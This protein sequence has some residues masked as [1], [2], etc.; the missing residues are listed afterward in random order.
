MA[1]HTWRYYQI[2]VVILSSRALTAQYR[3]ACYTSNGKNYWYSRQRWHY[4]HICHTQALRVAKK[5]QRLKRHLSV[6][7]FVFMISWSCSYLWLNTNLNLFVGPAVRRFIFQSWT[8]G[9]QHMVRVC[10]WEATQNNNLEP[11][12]C[13]TRKGLLVRDTVWRRLDTLRVSLHFPHLH[14]MELWVTSV[15]RLPRTLAVFV[16]SHRAAVPANRRFSVALLCCVFLNRRIPSLSKSSASLIH[17][18]E[19]KSSSLSQSSL[20]PLVVSL[21]QLYP[22]CLLHKYST[23]EIFQKTEDI[24]EYYYFYY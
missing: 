13:L 9:T 18:R 23:N 5:W 2:Y 16:Q 20:S 7:M 24:H 21:Q 17:R 12:L 4:C 6:S 19:N 3:F 11:D 10:I 15:L 8:R 22:H 1:C 14:R